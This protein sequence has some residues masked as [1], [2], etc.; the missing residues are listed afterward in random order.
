MVNL[1]RSCDP[2]QSIIHYST[3]SLCLLNSVYEW[4]YYLPKRNNSRDTA[5]PG[6]S[7]SARVLEDIA[8]HIPARLTVISYSNHSGQPP[9]SRM[10]ARDWIEWLL[11]SW[12]LLFRHHFDF[13][14]NC[15]SLPIFLCH[16]VLPVLSCCD[17]Y[18][19]QN[20]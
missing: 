12:V 16:C 10:L 15:T 19:L 14:C 13:C 7:Q 20:L 3:H 5:N 1:L 2:I 18:I 6:S 4:L 9:S 11:F 8:L 17:L